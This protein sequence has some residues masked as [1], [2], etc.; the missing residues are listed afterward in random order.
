M[1][2][3][4]AVSA[5]AGSA[6]GGLASIATTWL[7]HHAQDRARRQAEIIA[8]RRRLY[9]E[10]LEEASKTYADALTNHLEEPTRLVRLYALV[11]KLR[12]FAP[13]AVVTQA[14]EVMRTILETYSG[15]NRDFRTWKIDQPDEIDVL[16]SFAEVCRDDLSA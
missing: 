15:P 8:H 10:F 6:I 14:D 1:V 4:S 11:G 7:T 12:L 2:D 9:E 13:R 16:R 5:L 3:A